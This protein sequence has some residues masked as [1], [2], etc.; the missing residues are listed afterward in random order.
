MQNT[1]PVSIRVILSASML[2]VLAACNDGGDSNDGPL[3]TPTTP[4]PAV[5]N[6]PPVLAAIGAQSVEEAG[7]LNFTVTATDADATTPTLEVA[8]LPQGATFN[9]ADGTFNWAVMTGDATNSPYSVT[10]TAIDGADSSVTD[11]ETVAITVTAAPVLAECTVDVTTPVEGSLTAV[12]TLQEVGMQIENATVDVEG[13]FSC[14]SGIPAGWG[15]KVA[16]VG[17]NGDTGEI[18][19]TDA[20]FVANLTGLQKD[21]YILT[22]TVVDANGAD[23]LNASGASAED[24]VNSVGLGD[25]Y[26]AFGD[27]ITKGTGD[28]V[29]DNGPIVG[30]TEFELASADGRTLGGYPA[31]LNDALSNQLGYPHLI[32]NAGIEGINSGAGLVELPAVLAE[33]P[34]AQ[35]VLIMFGMNDARLGTARVDTATFKSNIQAM[36]DSVV[37]AGMEPA[38][39]K[40]NI[41]LGNTNEVSNGTYS[42]PNAG[43]RSV[44][45]QGFNT[46]IDELKAENAVS[47][48]TDIP[49]FYELFYQ[50]GAPSPR[51]QTEYLDNIHPNRTGYQSMADLWAGILAP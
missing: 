20:D 4:P 34:T 2:T 46:A 44:A 26:I 24:V 31:S 30:Q 19:I 15:V 18:I 45:I 10:F 5:T 48:I 42:D 39:A 13:T 14:T 38:I 28:N 22:A 33:H 50:G 7:T 47:F 27:S 25:Y 36:I 9:A 35:R 11:T 37:S 12:G 23:G 1:L 43:S 17:E 32:V 8:G 21:E 3:F 29:D 16:V 6:A 40:V 41:A 49:D 51:Y